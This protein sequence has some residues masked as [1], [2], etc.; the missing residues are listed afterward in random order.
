MIHYPGV[1]TPCSVALAFF[2]PRLCFGSTT[3]IPPTQRRAPSELIACPKTPRLV[4]PRRRAN[5]I[6]A[7]VLVNGMGD[8][9]LKKD[10]IDYLPADVHTYPPNC[11]T[12][13]WRLTLVNQH[14]GPQTDRS[15]LPS[16]LDHCRPCYLYPICD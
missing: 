9:A 12:Y 14:R 1:R 7:F 2:T 15:L 5:S 16:L 11:T 3:H 10:L 8:D 6:S 4:M 13:N